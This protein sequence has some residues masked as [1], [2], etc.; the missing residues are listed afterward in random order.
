MT[1]TTA[2]QITIN[3]TPY[4]VADGATVSQAL[5]DLAMP[6]EGIALAINN[7]VVPADQWAH[8]ALQDGDD[9]HIFQAI[10]GG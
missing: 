5:S 2:I 4:Q 8:K 9:L 1:A 6:K 7:A 3:Q 10:A